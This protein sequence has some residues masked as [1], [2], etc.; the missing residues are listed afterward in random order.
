VTQDDTR[1]P[2]GEG[3]TFTQTAHLSGETVRAIDEQVAWAARHWWVVL[4]AG[5]AGVIF[6]AIMLFD[7]WEGLRILAYFV[8]FYLLL[9]GIGDLVG[10]S[11]YEPR[12]L[13][14]VSG[15][16]ALVGGIVALV[17]PGLT[18][19]ALALIMGIAFLAWGFVKA[20]TALVARGDGWGW[21]LVGGVLMAV[22]GVAAMAWPDKTLAVISILIGIN[23]LI[24]GFSAVFQSFALRSAARKW[25]DAKREA[26]PA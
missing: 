10:S 20:L 21:S 23:A 22:V 13:G 9:A 14:V 6:G 7:F 1:E 8:G 3:L 17:Y 11:H 16:L 4:L 15:V 25:E 19:G 26:R 12:W 5:I 24:F 18:L 2:Q